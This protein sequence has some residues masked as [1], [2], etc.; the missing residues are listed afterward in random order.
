[1]TEIKEETGTLCPLEHFTA[2]LSLQN[3]CLETALLPANKFLR[4]MLEEQ[5]CQS[6]LVVL[7][8]QSDCNAALEH[9]SMNKEKFLSQFCL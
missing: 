6:L 1:M 2:L 9:P 8:M 3:Q 4:I 7:Y 5:V